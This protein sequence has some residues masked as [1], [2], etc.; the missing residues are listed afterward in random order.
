MIYF[1]GCIFALGS[2]YNMYEDTP[3]EERVHGAETI[4]IFAIGTLLSWI[5]VLFYLYLKLKK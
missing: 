4:F 1:T 5:T 3:K 2:L